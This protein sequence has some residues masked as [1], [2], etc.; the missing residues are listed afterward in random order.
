MSVISPTIRVLCGVVLLAL[1]VPPGAAGARMG[2]AEVRAGPRGGPC[3]TITPREDRLGT[4]DFLAVT[5]SDGHRL[6]WKMS[7]P[8]G[9]SFPL[10]FAMCVPYGGRV[11]S[12]PQT[13]AASLEPGR[14]YALHIDARPGKEGK[15]ATAYEAR[16]CL[17]VQPDGG[18]IVHQVWPGEREGGDCGGAAGIR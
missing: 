3:F 15:A 16:F 1:I 11:A 12:L 13:P 9:R 10:S 8:A 7:M 4:P 17:A 5:V 6:L 14:V 2:E 18:T